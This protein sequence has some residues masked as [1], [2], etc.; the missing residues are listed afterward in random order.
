MGGTG[1]TFDWS[2]NKFETKLLRSLINKNFG[3]DE[4]EAGQ[5]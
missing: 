5:I 4:K 1:K 3:Q 2:K